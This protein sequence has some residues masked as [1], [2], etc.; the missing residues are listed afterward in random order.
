MEAVT[1]T[2]V[3]AT[4]NQYLTFMLAGEEYGVDILTVQELRG[5]E[6]ATPIP[7]TP[8]YVRGVI[9]LRGVVVPIVDLRDR[10]NLERI[11]YGPTTVVVIVK[12]TNNEHQRVLGIVVDAVSEVYN[13]PKADLQPPPDME[14]SISI[15]YVKGLA[16]IENKMVILL[17]INKL[18]HEGILSKEKETSSKT[19]QP[20]EVVAEHG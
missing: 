10:F 2:E 9:N 6:P 15:D 19:G 20:A 4:E 7:N 8:S 5:W 11:D 3:N 16:T 1:T 14:G 13:I 12:V 18:V 17:D